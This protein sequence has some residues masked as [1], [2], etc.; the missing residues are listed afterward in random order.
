MSSGW[1][2]TLHLLQCSC[3]IFISHTPFSLQTPFGASFPH[4]HLAIRSA[5]DAS[6]AT[7]GTSRH[8]V[9]TLLEKGP[10]LQLHKPLCVHQAHKLSSNVSLELS[11]GLK[12]KDFMVKAYNLK[13]QH[14]QDYF[15]LVFYCGG[16]C[17]KPILLCRNTFPEHSTISSKKW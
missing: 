17:R 3:E 15:S 4:C 13:T 16:F 10:G 6:W 12:G 7:D 14:S 2:T 5:R 11:L 8:N 1:I 9:T